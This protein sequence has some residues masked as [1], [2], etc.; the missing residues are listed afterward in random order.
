LAGAGTVEVPEGGDPSPDLG[1]GA[2]ERA[3]VDGT[4]VAALV[5][6]LADALAG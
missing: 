6:R 4:N 5:P 2:E 1:L 3:L